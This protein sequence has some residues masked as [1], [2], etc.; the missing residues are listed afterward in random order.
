MKRNT[1]A[2]LTAVI[3]LGSAAAQVWGQDT[4]PP[5]Y[6][7]TGVMVT[8]IAPQPTSSSR[9]LPIVYDATGAMQ[10][11]IQPDGAPRSSLPIVY[12]AT[13]AM[14]TALQPAA[15]DSGLPIVYDATAAE[16]A[17]VVLPQ[18][19]IVPEATQAV[20][21]TTAAWQMDARLA[22]GLALATVALG[23]LWLMWR[24][25]T[26]HRAHHA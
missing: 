21:T 11:A 25:R 24:R 22:S 12:D 19:V 14:Q 7:S 4:I 16:Q 6:D 1:F 9:G 18:A 10:A 3:L 20:T 5:V 26:Q 15:A 13:G 8:A 23:G 2:L 17:A